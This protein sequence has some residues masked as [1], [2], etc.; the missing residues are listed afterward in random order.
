MC[1]HP[2]F[3]LGINEH[4]NLFFLVQVVVTFLSTHIKAAMCV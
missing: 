3:L 2:V 1:S 4:R